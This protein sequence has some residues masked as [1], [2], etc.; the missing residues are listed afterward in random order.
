M[1]RIHPDP[2]WLVTTGSDVVSADRNTWIQEEVLVSTMVKTQTVEVEV[3]GNKIDFAPAIPAVPRDQ[4]FKFVVRGLETSDYEKLEFG[5]F[6]KVYEGE[7]GWAKKED[8]DGAVFVDR[9]RSESDEVERRDGDHPFLAFTLVATKRDG[10]TF[11][12]DPILDERP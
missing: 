4:P 5:N 6:K 8:V 2:Q 1:E 12:I 3:A 10:A 9:H 11:V 7:N